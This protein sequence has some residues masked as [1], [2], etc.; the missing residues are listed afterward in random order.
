MPRGINPMS[1][2]R[3]EELAAE[4]KKI[5]QELLSAVPGSPLEEK[6]LREFM[7]VQKELAQIREELEEKD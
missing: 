5:R 7:Q 6:L 4:A 3:V 2:Q 1:E